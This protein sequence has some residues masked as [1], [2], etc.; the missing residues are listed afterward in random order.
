MVKELFFFYGTW[1]TISTF[2]GASHWTFSLHSVHVFT[3]LIFKTDFITNL[4]RTVSA[5]W[6]L[7]SGILPKILHAF[8]VS[9]LLATCLCYVI[10][11]LD[12]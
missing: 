8:L 1:R 5:K 10:I 9:P 4:M 6:P 2:R 3:S 11:N 12:I 7:L